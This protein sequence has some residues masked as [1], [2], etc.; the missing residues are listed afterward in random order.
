[1]FYLLSRQAYVALIHQVHGAT[2][3]RVNTKQIKTILVPHTNGDMQK[4]TVAQIERK[5]SICDS[6]EQT[7][8]TA[9]QQAEA[10]RQSILKKAFEG[11]L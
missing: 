6:I 8:N 7:I 1:M 3:P 5:L 2:R 10:M 9:L 4:E 11:G